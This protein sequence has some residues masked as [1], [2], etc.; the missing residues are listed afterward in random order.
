MKCTHFSLIC[1]RQNTKHP[2]AHTRTSAAMQ[3][4]KTQIAVGM[5]K[6]SPQNVFDLFKFKDFFRGMHSSGGSQHLG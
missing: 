4:N 5:R 6:A 2:P 1:K 3:S